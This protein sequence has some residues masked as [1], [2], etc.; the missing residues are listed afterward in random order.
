MKKGANWFKLVLYKWYHLE[1]LEGH[2]RTDQGKGKVMRVPTGHI[3]KLDDIPDPIVLPN[4]IAVYTM[5]N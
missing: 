4:E 3:I 5:P 2:Y 1:E